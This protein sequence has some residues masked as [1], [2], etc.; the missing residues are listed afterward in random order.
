MA[1]MRTDTSTYNNPLTCGLEAFGFFDLE[2]LSLEAGIVSTKGV[3]DAQGT[4]CWGEV[5]RER[6]T[7]G[8]GKERKTEEA[9]GCPTTGIQRALIP[10][11]WRPTFKFWTHETTYAVEHPREPTVSPQTEWG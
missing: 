4:G 11:S 5:S 2:E 6:L 8:G 7:R 3:K 1:P 9:R 10:T